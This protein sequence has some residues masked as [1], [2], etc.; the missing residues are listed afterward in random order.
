MWYFGMKLARHINKHINSDGPLCKSRFR[1]TLVNENEHAL[2][3][4]RYIHR[5][6]VTAGL[7]SSPNDY[8]WSSYHHYLNPSCKPKFL[9]TDFILGHHMDPQDFIDF[10]SLGNDKETQQFYGK[11]YVDRIWGNSLFTSKFK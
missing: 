1:D 11:Q 2:R 8:K 5:N 6:P 4:T 10:T 7:V 3:L 9:N